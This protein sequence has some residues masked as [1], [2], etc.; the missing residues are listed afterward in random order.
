MGYRQ[1]FAGQTA[2]KLVTLESTNFY[3]AFRTKF[4]FRI[5]PDAVPSRDNREIA[6]GHPSAALSEPDERSRPGLARAHLISERMHD[7][8]PAG[9]E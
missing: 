7:R 1:D 3:E 5:R 6:Y 9:C 8:E 4:N 2:F